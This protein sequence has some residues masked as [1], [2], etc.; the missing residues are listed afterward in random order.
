MAVAPV[1]A[2]QL[3][4]LA[5][6]DVEY[7]HPFTSI[8]SIRELS[9]GRVLVAD[10]R[11]QA[12]T[13]ID[14]RSQHAVS[15]G[16]RGQ[17]PGE[18]LYPSLLLAY[19]G[20]SSIV[21]DPPNARVLVVRSNGGTGDAFR[22]ELNAPNGDRGVQIALVRSVR[23]SDASGRLYMQEAHVPRGGTDSAAIMRYDRTTGRIDTIAYVRLP[24]TTIASYRTPTGGSLAVPLVAPFPVRDEWA[25]A[26]NG[27]VAV[28]RGSDYHVDIYGP[29]RTKIS[30]P[31][32]RFARI[33]ITD[34]EKQQYRERAARETPVFTSPNG[35]GGDGALAAVEPTT[36]PQFEP[37]FAEHAVWA[38]S[39]GEFWVARARAVGDVVETYDVFDGSGQR[40]G[41]AALPAKVRLVGFGRGAVYAV[42]VD[43]DDFQYLQRYR[44]PN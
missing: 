44:L 4:T 37:P 35:G 10:T 28:F 17:G 13:L 29:D 20:D 32:T 27:R 43:D 2:Q 5:K 40:T 30:G 26:P 12:V 31:P 21:V 42:R 19:G 8:A 41:T 24:A 15:V 33:P 18:Y 11:D 9:D 38:R 39:N 36:W 1:R 7:A 16:R 22:V 25:V 23:G 14:L 34:A 6:P 3:A